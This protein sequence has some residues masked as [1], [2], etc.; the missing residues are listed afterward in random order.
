M[1]TQTMF[2][3]VFFCFK[4]ELIIII[5]TLYTKDLMLSYQ[6]KTSVR[7]KSIRDSLA[8]GRRMRVK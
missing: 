8:R 7:A 2:S 4:Y 6:N 1:T 5:I 3:A